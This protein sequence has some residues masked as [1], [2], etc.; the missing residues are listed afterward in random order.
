MTIIGDS[1]KQL[2]SPSVVNCR[3]LTDTNLRKISHALKF[4]N[5][6]SV[7]ELDANSGYNFIVEKVTS[8]LD[9]IA[10]VKSIKIDPSKIAREPWMTVGLIKSSAICDK[11]FRSSCGLDKDSPKVIQ[12]KLYR[13][14]YN[15]MKRRAKKE[16]FI[17]KI[18]QFR[19]N[20]KKMWSILKDITGKNNDK[21]SCSNTFTINGKSVN[22]TNIIRNEFSKYYGSMGKNLVERI[23][24]SQKH[25]S[26]FLSPAENSSLYL[27]P[28]S[29]SEI[30]KIV[31]KMKNKKSSGHDG[32]S[33]YLSKYIVQ[34]LKYALSVVF[35]KS[36]QE[37]IYPNETG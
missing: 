24:P 4:V 14:L 7:T 27:Y 10:P 5:W 34:D 12:Y 20:A 1:K 22:D 33:N 16:Y 37:G 31:T 8:V 15:T 11:K 6:Q 23:G 18:E 21:S 2:A 36:I 3:K 25:F 9:A 19:T 13:N 32:I 30:V 17:N 29:Q 35:N 28:T 26:D